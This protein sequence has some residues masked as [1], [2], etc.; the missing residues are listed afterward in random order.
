MIAANGVTA[1]FLEAK[2][3]PS[4]RRVVRSPER[5]LRIVTVASEHGFTLPPE[6]DAKAL[7]T[8]LDGSGGRPTRCASRTSPS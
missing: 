8:F 4:L 6:P 5:W 1:R 3:F 7:E 2:G